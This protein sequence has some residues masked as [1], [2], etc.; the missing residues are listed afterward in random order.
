MSESQGPRS[1]DDRFASGIPARIEVV[2][3]EVDRRPLVSAGG[4]GYLWELEQ[5]DGPE[6]ARLGIE[7]GR[8]PVQSSDELPTNEPVPL[9]LAV[10]GVHE[11]TARWRGR[12]VRPW[13]PEAPLVDRMI[14]VVGREP[15]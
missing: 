2:A 6:A 10:T 9:Q 5:I 1:L 13:V 14:D 3:G 15:P 7:A 8:S 12:L 4:S 11:G